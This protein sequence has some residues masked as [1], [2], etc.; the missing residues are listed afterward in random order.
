M[1]KR[2][3][4]ITKSFLGL[5]TAAAL[6]MMGT[7]SASTIS[8]QTNTNLGSCEAGYTCDSTSRTFMGSDGI[9]SVTATAW[10]KNSSNNLIETA[11]LGFYSNG[12]G[13]TNNAN[14]G[15]HTVDN[16]GYTDFVAFHFSESV[17]MS[18][19]DLSTYSDTDITVWIGTVSADPDFAGDSFADLDA[20]FGPGFNNYGNN[21][22]RTANF[23][24]DSEVGNLLI[25]SALIDNSESVYDNFKIR[26]LAAEGLT[27]TNDDVPAPA[28][29]LVFGPAVFGLSM[30]RRR[31]R[32][33]LKAEKAAAESD[34]ENNEDV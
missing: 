24:S 6:S 16:Q 14:D 1:T 7:A 28:S 33:R 31:S 10:S 9:T 13:V 15:S 26:A 18:S 22:D 12:L 32:A 29:L 3:N 20:A 34:E 17:D 11:Q 2:S 27:T 4:I 23:G 5:A 8:W 19:V 21:A 25:I 30:M